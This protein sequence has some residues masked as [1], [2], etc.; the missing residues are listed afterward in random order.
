M[1]RARS[2]S[3][4]GERPRSSRVRSEIVRIATVFHHTV[5]HPR[6]AHSQHQTLASLINFQRIWCLQSYVQS[7]TFGSDFSG[8]ILL[9]LTLLT[10]V[11]NKAQSSVR[12]DR[13]GNS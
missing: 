1:A 8:K 5:A 4:R 6:R 2:Q 3:P 9:A 11:V 12:V 10:L 7:I 13:K